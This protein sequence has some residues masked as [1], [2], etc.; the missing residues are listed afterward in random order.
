MVSDDTVFYVA[1]PNL[2]ETL[3]E[4]NKIIQER[5]AQNPEL[6]QWWDKE[7]ASSRGSEEWDKV[8]SKI[9]EFGTQLGDEIVVTAQLSKSGK[10][11]PDGRGRARRLRGTGNNDVLEI[12]RRRHWRS[13]IGG[14][15]ADTHAGRQQLE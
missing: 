6:S 3:A 8:I 1:I 9:A 13:A 5:L 10:G 2:T 7:Q 12:C 4:S 11:E 15:A 14:V